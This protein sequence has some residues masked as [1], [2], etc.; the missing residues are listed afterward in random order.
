MTERVEYQAQPQE[1]DPF[2]CEVP[3]TLCPPMPCSPHP[4]Q[5]RALKD[6]A[7]QTPWEPNPPQL[8]LPPSTGAGRRAGTP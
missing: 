2:W 5:V 8:V 6:L 3:S 7:P 4:S 1:L